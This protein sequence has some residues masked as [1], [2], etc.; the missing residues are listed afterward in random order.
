MLVSL[1]LACQR[2]QVTKWDTWKSG[3]GSYS[4]F[5]STYSGHQ[6]M[7]EIHHEIQKVGAVVWFQ[8]DQTHFSHFTA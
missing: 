1:L 5:A 4:H 7:Q 3:I 2:N 6:T 8:L